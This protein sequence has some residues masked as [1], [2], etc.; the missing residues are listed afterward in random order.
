[1]RDNKLAKDTK[2]ELENLIAPMARSASTI[3]DLLTLAAYI[4]A[5]IKEEDYNA[6]VHIQEEI[7]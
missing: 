1:M 4:D 2:D 5:L 6:K 3:K 7:K